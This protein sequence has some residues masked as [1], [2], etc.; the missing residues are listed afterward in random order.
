M[1]HDIPP[2][3]MVTF[4]AY[5]DSSRTQCTAL[6]VSSAPMVVKLLAT[7]PV[8]VSFLADINPATTR[9]VRE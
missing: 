1:A 6:P 3:V 9:C 4:A 2:Q 5:T 7:L 8:F